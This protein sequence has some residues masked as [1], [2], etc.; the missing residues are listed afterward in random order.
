MAKFNAGIQL[1]GVDARFI[2]ILL[3]AKDKSALHLKKVQV[4]GNKK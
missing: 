1:P 4:Y 2:K 3:K